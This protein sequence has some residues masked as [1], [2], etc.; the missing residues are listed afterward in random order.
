M[1]RASIARLPHRPKTGTRV[2]LES[3]RRR[4]LATSIARRIGWKG[5]DATYHS[6][7][8]IAVL[9]DTGRGCAESLCSSS[10]GAGRKLSRTE[11][12]QQIT[13]RHLHRQMG[14][15]WFDHRRA[16]A[17]RDEAP[18]AYKDILAVMRAQR[19]LTRIVRELRPILSYKG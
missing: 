2:A 1:K 5:K 14:A 4:N 9:R 7:I 12:R 8:W 19:E 13:Q 11:A 3:S 18:T 6:K 10:H 16:D 17:L 15:V